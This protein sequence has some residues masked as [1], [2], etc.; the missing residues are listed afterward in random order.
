M[1]SATVHVVE[2]AAMRVEFRRDAAGRLVLHSIE[3]RVDGSVLSFPPGPLFRVIVRASSPIDSFTPLD[4]DG[5]TGSTV[6]QIEHADGPAPFGARFEQPPLG[7]RNFLRADFTFDSIGGRE[8]DLKIVFT[9]S[10]LDALP[11]RLLCACYFDTSYGR[12]MTTSALFWCAPILL[13]MRPFA[14][15]HYLIAMNGGLVTRNPQVDLVGDGDGYRFNTGRPVG[16]TAQAH[17]LYPAVGFEPETAPAQFTDRMEVL[18]PTWASTALA[19][20]GSRG[21]DGTTLYLHDSLHFAPRRLRDTFAGGQLLLEHEA[22][23]ENGIAAGNGWGAA[24]GADCRRAET[25]VRLFRRIGDV[26]GEAVGLD[27]Q[28]FTQSSP[29]GRLITPPRLIDRPD[30]SA[31]LRRSPLFRTYFKSDDEDETGLTEAIAEEFREAFPALRNEPLYR[32]NYDL[33]YS[34]NNDESGTH[35]GAIGNSVPDLFDLAADPGKVAY[36]QEL[37]DEYGLHTFGAIVVRRPTPY[38][39][40]GFWDSEAMDAARVRNH[41]EALDPDYRSTDEWLKVAGEVTAVAVDGSFTAITLSTEALD[42][43]LWDNFTTYERETAGIDHADHSEHLGWLRRRDGGYAFTIERQGQADFTASP[44]IL[45]IAG[46]QSGSIVAG[47]VV[48][49]HFVEPQ[50]V[51]GYDAGAS[52]RLG[53][54]APTSLCA[55]ADDVGAGTGAD[56]GWGVRYVR[57]FVAKCRPWLTGVLH[58]LPRLQQVCFGHHGGEIPGSNQQLLGWRRILAHLRASVPPPFELWEEDGPYDWLLGLVDGHTRPNIRLDLT[59]SAGSWGASPFFQTAWGPW[60]RFG[61]YLANRE[62]HFTNYGGGDFYSAY[63]EGTASKNF[64]EALVGDF[65]LGRLPSVGVSPDPAHVMGTRRNGEPAYTP[66]FHATHGMDVPGSLA[67]LCAR[68]VQFQLAFRNVNVFGQRCRSLQRLGTTTVATNPL[69]IEPSHDD[70]HNLGVDELGARRAPLFHSVTQ[71]PEQ[72][73]RWIALFVNESRSR[74]SS[75]YRFDPALYAEPAALGNGRYAVTRFEVAPGGVASL[76][77]SV[78]SGITELMVALEAA[79]VAVIT[80]E[81]D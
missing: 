17:D 65:M 25:Y 53:D 44:P 39:G 13:R 80:F 21:A 77:K 62:G 72:P 10:L 45:R 57:E 56:R 43:S 22:L 63:F 12:G 27:Y 61:G 9:A 70:F 23:I 73:R 7:G 60:Y 3:N 42:P 67:G 52:G 29:E 30:H 68:L 71:D 64:R 49:V 14:R 34:Y 15:D 33:L 36:A 78:A 26:L 55:M 50:Y 19:A 76:S 41:L 58:V 38:D 81:L 8:D 1:A 24:S 59:T 5:A 54:N 47:D 75:R 2:S 6:P 32:V 66:F 4:S 79:E 16:I 20:Y 40:H 46:D 31:G 28:R 74:R 11:D 35:G 69:S 18:Y 51:P 37:R 48:D